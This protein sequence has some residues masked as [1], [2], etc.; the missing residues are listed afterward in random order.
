MIWQGEHGFLVTSLPTWQQCTAREACCQFF[1]K[2]WE[3]GQTVKWTWYESWLPLDTSW[4]S[5]S[6]R[7]ETVD[8]FGDLWCL[9][10]S[11]CSEP[12]MNIS[13]FQG[14]TRGR[15][16]PGADPK[17]AHFFATEEPTAPDMQCRSL[18][19]RSLAV[20]LKFQCWALTNLTS[21]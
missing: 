1:A 20:T 17:H 16:K 14:F 9:D 10:L 4:A 19:H 3:I 13:Q 21:L 8:D 15:Q 18:W 11:L 12:G 2:F 6:R 5:C 7:V